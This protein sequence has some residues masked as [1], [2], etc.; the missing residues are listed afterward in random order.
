MELELDM[1]AVLQ[2]D[3]EFEFPFPLVKQF[4]ANIR[5]RWESV[6]ASPQKIKSILDLEKKSL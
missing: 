6:Q 4:Y 5:S 2:Y 1:L 3:F